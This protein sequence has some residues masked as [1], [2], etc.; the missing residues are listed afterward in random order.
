MRFWRRFRKVDRTPSR[1]RL[2]APEE[3]VFVTLKRAAWRRG[4]EKLL[5]RHGARFLGFAASPTQSRPYVPGDDL[6]FLDERLRAR[7][8]KDYVKL[9]ALDSSLSCLFFVDGTRSMSF[10]GKFDAA[11]EIVWFG[12]NLLVEFGDAFA[13]FLPGAS[14]VPFL[15]FARGRAHLA[16]LKEILE[17]A[18]ARGRAPVTGNLVE[19]AGLLRGKSLGVIVSDFIG[20]RAEILNALNRLAESGSDLVLVQVLTETERAFPFSGTVVLIDPET[21][22]RR[23]IEAEEA[24]STYRE[25]ADRVARELDAFAGAR[26]FGY[27]RI[28]PASDSPVDLWRDLFGERRGTK[29]W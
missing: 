6:R 3:G 8:E 14:E 29:R 27:F 5:G 20:P 15:P 1:R 25:S 17:K 23:S 24:A 13:L 21:G 10:G 19:S 22:K 26:G 28:D 9:A 12:A 16:E 2:S 11:C 7:T 18:E 4:T